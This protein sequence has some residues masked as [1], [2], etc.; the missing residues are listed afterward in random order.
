MRTRIRLWLATL[1]MLLL[2][3]AAS[4]TFA[5]TV[6]Y[7]YD[8]AGRLVK[9]E[10]SDVTITYTYDPAGNVLAVAVATPPASSQLARDDMQ[11]AYVAY[12]GRPADPDGLN[13]WAAQLDAH[14]QSLVAIIDAFGNSDEF[15]RRYGGL[16]YTQLVTKIYQQTLGR[17]PEQGGLDFYVG[18]LL[19]GLL[20][21]QS[22]T[23][24]VL[25]GA[26]TPPDSTVVANKLDVAAYY[27]AKVAAGCLYG[28]EQDGVNAL[29]GV[30]AN[31][32]TVTAAKAAIDGRCGP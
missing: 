30:T 15:N 4:F 32:A 16:S 2:S 19:L 5:A 24:D 21:L 10:Y 29:S 17:D 11:K 25:Y 9:A 23:L 28:T 13:F 1:L 3:C 8:A 18:K 7:A 6:N 22:I 31:S 14:G 27:T 12:Y 26:T 20:T